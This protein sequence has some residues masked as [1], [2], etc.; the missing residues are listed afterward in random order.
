[1]IVAQRWGADTPVS[2]QIGMNC[3]IRRINCKLGE[4]RWDRGEVKTTNHEKY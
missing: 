4:G 3:T 1:M 2:M